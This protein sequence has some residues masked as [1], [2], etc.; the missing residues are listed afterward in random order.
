M[1]LLLL[2]LLLLL[3][4]LFGVGEVE[5]GDRE[6]FEAAEVAFELFV[7]EV[8]ELLPFPPPPTV[9]VI[10]PFSDS[11]DE[12]DM[13][14]SRL[15]EPEKRIEV[16][17][18]NKVLLGLFVPI[19]QIERR[20]ASLLLPAFDKKTDKIIAK[21]MATSSFEA[22]ANGG[23]IPFESTE[24]T[25]APRARSVSVTSIRPLGAAR[26]KGLKAKQR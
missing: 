1:L 3:F 10:S 9:K 19:E 23:E 5:V 22:H 11:L 13:S 26:C 21:H 2:L 14:D 8:V 16:G 24:V 20:V 6:R 4:W 12:K 25:E 15:S 7:S 17:N 18:Q